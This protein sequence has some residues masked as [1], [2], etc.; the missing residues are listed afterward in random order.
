[1]SCLCST[2]NGLLV[3]VFLSSLARVRVVKYGV[4]RFVS[5]VGAWTYI[6]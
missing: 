6:G 4:C 3:L 2:W 1:M 5:W